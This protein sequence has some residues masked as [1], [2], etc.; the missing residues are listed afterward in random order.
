MTTTTT[1]K[2]QPADRPTPTLDRPV[3]TVPPVRKTGDR[4]K[5]LVG[6]DLGTNASCVLAGPADGRDTTVSKVIPTIVGYAREG[7][8]DGI[9][10]NNATTLIGEEALTHRLQMKMVAPLEDGIIAH[11]EPARDFIRRVRTV[12]DP[13]NAAEIRAVIGVP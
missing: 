8:V 12:I 13:T 10:A 3:D 11:V 1:D 2:K 4:K 6:F 9:I 7:L 5:I